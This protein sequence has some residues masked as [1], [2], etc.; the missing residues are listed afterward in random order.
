MRYSVPSKIMWKRIFLILLSLLVLLAGAVLAFLYLRRPAQLPASADKVQPTPERLA[1]GRYLFENLCDCGGC[2]SQRDFTRFGAPEVTSG[3]GQGSIFPPE[4][5]LPGK[6]VASNITPDPETGIG[7][8]TDGEKIRAIRD[9][10]D[11]HG[12]ALFPMMPYTGYRH[13]SDED[14]AALVAY[15]DSLPPVRN[16]LPP[17]QVDF[18]VSLLI[19]GAPQPAGQ[20]P[21]PDRSNTLAY[22]EY[23]VTLGGC[24]D[25]HTPAE[26]GQPVPGKRLAG[27]RVFRMP[28]APC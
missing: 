28:L 10:V 18:P 13:M 1:R 5:G 23:L 27:G 11:R 16:A 22:G 20:I 3:R 26:K 24:L 4:M 2:H 15:L 8:W 21:P 17:T 6:I 7:A 19:K 9:G 12:R 14:V 25:C